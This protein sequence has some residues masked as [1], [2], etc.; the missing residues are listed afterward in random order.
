M[1]SLLP[2]EKVKR[3]VV[4]YHSLPISNGKLDL[5]VCS[6]HDR[7]LGSLASS[8]KALKDNNIVNNQIWVGCPINDK[9]NGI[10]SELVKD[11]NFVP[12][13]TIPSK[14]Y[15]DA[16]V[17]FSHKYLRPVFHYDISSTKFD[18]NHWRSYIEFNI[19]FARKIQSIY[20]EGDILWIHGIQLLLLPQFLR[21]L[22]PTSTV[23]LFLH[24][25]FPAVEVYRCLPTRK[26]LLLGMLG[27]NLIAFQAYS[28]SRYFVQSC[29]RILGSHV[30]FDGVKYHNPDTNTDML[31]RVSVFS[32]GIDPSEVINALAVKESQLRIK[33]LEETFKG[34]KIIISKDKG[35]AIEATK[36]KLLA[37]ER[38]LKKNPNWIG[39]VVFFLVCEPYPSSSSC[40]TKKDKIISNINE[41]VARIN[42]EYG[43]VGIIPIQYINRNVDFSEMCS[44]FHVSD[45]LLSTPLR[46]GMNLDT[47]DFVVSHRDSLSKPG[48]VILSEFD[49]ASRCFGGAKLVNPWCVNHIAQAITEA[50]EQNTD[51]AQINHDH[52]LNYVLN[53]TSFLWGEAFLYD[54]LSII[55]QPVNNHT[56]TLLD[57]K[58]LDKSYR[59]SKKRLLLFDYDSA[60]KAL[61]PTSPEL[62]SSLPSFGPTKNNSVQNR[63]SNVLKK[64]SKDPNNIIYVVSRR[65]KDTLENVL[66]NI[67]V[68]L[69]C[70]NGNFL[71]SSSGIPGQEG[72]WENLSAGQ[73]MS[74]R[75][76]VSQI[77]EHFCE[78]LPGSNITTNT[79]TLSF[80]Y[81]HC[82]TDYSSEVAQELLTTLIEVATKSPIDI[83]HNNKTIEIQPSGI[84]KGYSMKK[85]L[86]ENPSI[87]F[88]LCVGDEKTDEDL[89]DILD[90][91]NSSHYSISV[92]KKKSNAKYYVQDKSHVI[93]TLEM[94]S[95]FSSLS[96]P[97][98]MF[99]FSQKISFSKDLTYTSTF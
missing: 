72:E 86:D 41:T 9:L 69:S 2:K 89:F 38:V 63:I 83:S 81:E 3:L 18:E 56:S 49:G 90:D 23:G 47:H 88:I 34:K 1:E 27:S 80:S 39:Q 32:E 78:R 84:G 50:L 98:N 59:L 71:K 82:Q 91:N 28:Y 35:D 96:P 48:T 61:L 73:D 92:G 12:V 95:N 85:V 20:Q 5:N 30:G 42:G 65:D 74:W 8:V 46:E 44:L 77:L 57:I 87:D 40:P 24:C 51:V 4:I 97:N 67:P 45:I 31:T 22:I 79:I 64:L 58:L 36:N 11:D 53:N 19:Q 43:A 33:E 6:Y 55:H 15:E 62:P 21:E 7:N 93:K 75:E 54:I 26:K 25:P 68:G 52:N 76:V 14:L 10:E 29:T 37:F 16:C 70:E 66:E 13:N 99:T 17:N 60:F 94:I